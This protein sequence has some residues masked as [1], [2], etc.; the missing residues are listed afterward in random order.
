MNEE[1]QSKIKKENGI[2]PIRLVLVVGLYALLLAGGA[3]FINN[4][5]WTSTYM[6]AGLIAMVM[7]TAVIAVVL[8]IAYKKGSLSIVLKIGLI[9]MVVMTV[10]ANMSFLNVGYFVPHNT[11]TIHNRYYSVALEASAK[12]QEYLT[13]KTVYMDDENEYLMQDVNTASGIEISAIASFRSSAKQILPLQH[14]SGNLNTAQ[15]E[16]LVEQKSEYELVDQSYKR[17]YSMYF[18]FDVKDAEQVIFLMGQNSTLFFITPQ[19]YS[20]VRELK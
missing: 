18:F 10:L 15:T 5:R 17:V 11:T 6:V 9:A 4:S 20:Q 12:L 1:K 16:Y 3:G 14:Q 2:T 19:L 8:R 7:A 13:E